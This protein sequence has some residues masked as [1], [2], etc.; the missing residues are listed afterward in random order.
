VDLEILLALGIEIA[1]ALDAAHSEGHRVQRRDG[2][3][4]VAGLL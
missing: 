4:S 3:S 1:D 2:S